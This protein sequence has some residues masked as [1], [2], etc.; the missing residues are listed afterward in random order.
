MQSHQYTEFRRLSLLCDLFNILLK[1]FP[2]IY[3]SLLILASETIFL[4]SPSHFLM[5]LSSELC[6]LCGAFSLFFFETFSTGV[7]SLLTF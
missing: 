7:D 1:S 2:D 6:E 4:R 5:I 3:L